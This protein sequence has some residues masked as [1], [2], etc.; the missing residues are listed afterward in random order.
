MP[1]TTDSKMTIDSNNPHHSMFFFF[2]NDTA[3]TEIYTLSL[4]DALPI[5]HGACRARPPSPPLLR[6]GGGDRLREREAHLCRDPV[7]MADPIHPPLVGRHLHWCGRG[8][9]VPDVP[10]E[11]VSPAAGAHVAHGRRVVRHRPR[12]RLLGLP[13]ALGRGRLLRDV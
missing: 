8:P 12:V 1:H 4:P 6:A 13:A 2:F 11:G 7:R 5:F 9:P 3:T 10:D